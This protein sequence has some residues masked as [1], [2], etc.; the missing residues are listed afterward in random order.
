MEMFASKSLQ[1][2]GLLFGVCSPE[3]ILATSVVEVTKSCIKAET[4]SV[5]D[6]RMGSAGADDEDALCPTCENTGRECPGHF[7]H[8]ELAKPVVLFYKET[9]AW[10]KRCCHVCGTVGNEPRPFFF[11][12]YSACDACGAQRPLVRLVD[13]H[14]PCAIRVTV[15]RKDGEPETMPPE[16]ILATLDRVRDSDVDR[17]LGR[18]KG[19]HVRFH[20]RRLV[21]TRMPVLPP[22]CRPNAR[23]WPDGAMQDD[24]LSVFVSQI[25]KVNQRIKALEHDNPAVE[26]LVAQLRLKTL[27]FVDNTKGKVM[28]ATNRKPMVGI[29]ERIGKKGGLLRQNIMGKRRNQTGRSVVGPDGT[30]EVDEVGVPEAIADNLTVPVMV[31]PFNVSS[32]EA[33]MREGRVSSVEMRDGTVHRPSEWRPSHGD[34]METADGYPLGRVTRPSYDARDPSVVL[35]SWKTGETVTRPPPF[36]WPKLEPGMT[37]TRCLVDGDPVALNRQPTLHRNSMLGMRVK[38]LPGKTIRLNLSVTSG[39]NMDFDGDEGNLYLPQGPQARSETMLLMNPKSVI[40]S[41]RGPH[42]EVSLVQD[43]VLGCHLMSLNS[44]IPCPPEELAACLMEIHG[45]EGWDVR[46]V[47]KGATPRDLLSSVLPSTLTVDCGGGCRIES[48]KIVSGHLTKSA[49]KKIVRAV[50]LENG[51]DAAGKLVDKLQFLTNAWLSHRPFSVGYSDCL[52]ERPEETVRMVADA[53]CAKILEAEAA[54]DEDGVSV[55]LCG[56][57][58]RGQAVT[59]AAL[60]PDNRMAVMS[61]AQSKGDMFNL[62][63]IAG[64]LGQQYVGGSRPGKE[65]DGGRRS[66]P[67]YP[68]VWDSEQTTLKYESRGFV[69][70][71]FLKGLNPRE[72]FFHAKSGREG[73][74][75]TSQMTGVTGYAERK[76]VKLNEDL[77]SAYDGTVRDAMGNVVQFVYGGHG[78]DPQRCWSDG[79]PVN[80]KTL[81]EECSSQECSSQISGLRSPAVTSVEEASLLVPVGLCP[82]A[83]D[84]VRESLVLKHASVILKGAEEHPCED[85][86]AWRERVARSYAAAVLCPGEAVGVLCAQSIGAKQTQ[87][88]LDTF[89]KAGGWLDDAGSVPFGELLGLSQKPMRRQC[90]VPLKVDP[91]TPGDEVRDLV[92]CLF[93]RRDLLDL[94]A[95]RPSTATVGKT[96]SLELDPVKCFELRISPADVAYA[97]AEKFPPP[98]F[99]VSVSSFGVTLSWSANYPVDNLFTGLFSVQVGG[100]PG[101]E[102][103]RLLRGRDGGW[104]AVTKGT[105]LGAFL[106]HPLADWE[107]VRTDDVWDVYETLGLAAAKKRLYELMF[108]C[109]GDNL[110]PAH[111]KLLTD[112]MMRRGRPTPIDRYTMRTCEVGPLSRAAFEESLD[113]LTGAGCTAETEHCAGAGAR[114]AAG[115]PVRAGTGYMGLL[116][117]KGFFD[118]P[119]VKVPEADGREYVDYSYSDDESFEWR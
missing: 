10:L 11:A 46:D 94:L 18:G 13:A 67:H 77:V 32:L 36:S 119:V 40:M 71:S 35:R 117:G 73:M 16:L 82:G 24:N 91:S 63:Q 74:I 38:R 111:I 118:E 48:G 51:G 15:R 33:M 28:H 7:G 52:T 102:S 70:S 66:L 87:Q 98:H 103:Y 53:V 97:V 85:H 59:C 81:A 106:C 95:V 3:E 92:G 112:R 83:P 50:C 68:R 22:C 65:I 100:T 57:R 110:Y 44:A 58:D 64:L 78:M 99:D 14:D 90:V 41:A 5:Y 1:V 60:T 29:K 93:V 20:P 45:C 96:A 61:R 89:H 19:S 26:G 109:V 107:R 30:L 86:S 105:N 4:G 8:I 34:H 80:F 47:E 49:V 62:T 2:E 39:F 76:M 25:V 115:L 55:A 72:V 113:I 43:G 21:M 116:C 79:C 9:V 56:A 6:P 88:T 17:V 27:C 114:V 42:A 104:V 108:S 75:S 23:Q 12:P 101:V 37:V 69:R 84:P 54:D 31:T